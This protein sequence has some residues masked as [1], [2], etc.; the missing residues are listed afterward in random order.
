MK[1]VV[2]KKKQEDLICN[3][4]PRHFSFIRMNS[5]LLGELHVHLSSATAT[6]VMI[7]TANSAADINTLHFDPRLPEAFKILGV[8]V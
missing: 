2:H 8:D 4:S 3:G 1:D 6:K 5:T 7:I